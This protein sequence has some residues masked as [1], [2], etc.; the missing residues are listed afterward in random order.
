MDI[1]DEDNAAQVVSAKKK[2]P[3]LNLDEAL[4][5]AEMQMDT[6]PD[7]RKH[8]EAIQRHIDQLKVG[9]LL[10]RVDSLVALNEVISA[11][12]QNNESQDE[13]FRLYSI[14]T[15][16]KQRL[17][18]CS[19]TGHVGEPGLALRELKQTGYWTTQACAYCASPDAPLLVLFSDPDAPDAWCP[20]PLDR[21]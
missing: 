2:Q 9:D 20:F 7:L 6:D 14:T 5:M 12:G 18:A 1:G 13:G 21:I 19:C 4:N 10:K 16:K 11:T 8:M 17:L 3:Q 15:A